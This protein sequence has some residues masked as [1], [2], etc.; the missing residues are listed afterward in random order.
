MRY[1]DERNLHLFAPPLLLSRRITFILSITI[2]FTHTYIRD[3]ILQSGVLDYGPIVKDSR[4]RP[5]PSSQIL[6][7]SWRDDIHWILLRGCF[8]TSFGKDAKDRLV[9]RSSWFWLVIQIRIS[10][11]YKGGGAVRGRRYSNERVNGCFR[12]V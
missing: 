11:R 8:R 1:S 5:S 10:R 2:F 9:K 6:E 4:G 3:R 7:M 12:V